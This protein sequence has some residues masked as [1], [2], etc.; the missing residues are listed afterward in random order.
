MNLADAKHA[1][2]RFSAR[3]VLSL[4]A[5]AV[6]GL[7]GLNQHQQ[8][9]HMQRQLETLYAEIDHLSASDEDMRA[10]LYH[11][12][13]VISNEPVLKVPLAQN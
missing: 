6:L 10:K 5:F 11:I 9:R 8:N 12:R 2:T 1:K 7:I 4:I 13:D 3:A